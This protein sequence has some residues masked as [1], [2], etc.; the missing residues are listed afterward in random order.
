[1]TEGEWSSMSCR[2]RA[3]GV[4]RLGDGGTPDSRSEELDGRM[5]GMLRPGVDWVEW[6]P[7]WWVSGWCW[8]G[9]RLTLT[10]PEQPRQSRADRQSCQNNRPTVRAAPLS[11][12]RVD[13]DS[14]LRSCANAM[15]WGSGLDRRRPKRRLSLSLLLSLARQSGV[16][17]TSV[18]VS[19]SRS[20]SKSTSMS[21]CCAIGHHTTT[22]TACS[23]LHHDRVA[24]LQ[25]DLSHYS[26]AERMGSEHFVP[27]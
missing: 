9:A 25:R 10:E 15:Q 8:S 7:G 21:M 26:Q 22:N 20:T 14:A 24:V 5:K 17:V 3:A 4:V 11:C 16:Q 27:L 19:T 12:S 13:V 23:N 1:V 2:G 6:V 18:S